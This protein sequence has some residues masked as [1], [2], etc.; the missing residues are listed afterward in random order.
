ML[1]VVY[2]FIFLFYL[3][4]IIKMNNLISL[5]LKK[6]KTHQRV[7]GIVRFVFYQANVYNKLLPRHCSLQPK[8]H[9]SQMFSLSIDLKFSTFSLFIFFLVFFKVFQSL[10]FG[11]LESLSMTIMFVVVVSVT[12]SCPNLRGSIDHSIL[13][14]LSFTVSWS[15]LKFKSIELVMLSNTS[16]SAL[17][18]PFAFNLSQHQGL[19][20]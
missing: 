4:Y 20:Q 14:S 17:P 5:L 12:K 19:F 9:V 10:E 18:S 3:I 15:F 16:S 7:R 11:F 8:P 13:A 1:I 2:I 6:K